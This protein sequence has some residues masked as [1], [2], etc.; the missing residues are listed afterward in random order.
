MTIILY[1]KIF[2]ISYRFQKSQKKIQKMLLV[3]NIIAIMLVTTNS[4][5]LEKNKFDFQ[6]MCNET[7]LRFSISLTKICFKS[8]LPRAMEKHD[9]SALRPT[10]LQG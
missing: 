2:K 3:L 7:L 1:S 10:L 8:G 5:N 6:S 4:L 9:E